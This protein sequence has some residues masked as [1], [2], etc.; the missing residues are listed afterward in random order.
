MMVPYLFWHG[1]G[2]LYIEH[3]L[4]IYKCAFKPRSDFEVNWFVGYRH[5]VDSLR[6]FFCMRMRRM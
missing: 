4:N 1:N 6:C 5:L 3:L 2:V